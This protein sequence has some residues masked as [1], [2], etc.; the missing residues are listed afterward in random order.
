MV[1][2]VYQIDVIPLVDPLEVQDTVRRH[3]LG[4]Y[5]R[6]MRNTYVVMPQVI[7]QC[8]F[9]VWVRWIYALPGW[10]DLPLIT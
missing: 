8:I 5:G 7:I 6:V 10:R 2:N 1:V 3:V 4:M 9:I